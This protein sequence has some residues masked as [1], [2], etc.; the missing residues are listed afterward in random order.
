MIGFI[1]IAKWKPNDQ[2][3]IISGWLL[4]LI[5]LLPCY[6]CFLFRSKTCW[7]INTALKLTIDFFSVYKGMN[8]LLAVMAFI[9]VIFY[10]SLYIFMYIFPPI[11]WQNM[12]NY[13]N[14]GNITYNI[15]FYIVPSIRWNAKSSWYVHAHTYKKKYLYIYKY[16]YAQIN[17]INMK[18]I[19]LSKQQSGATRKNDCFEHI[20]V[21][22]D[23]ICWQTATQY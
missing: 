9:H 18:W 3:S 2:P 17:D 14:Y 6:C 21:W 16:I 8:N 13:S 11:S 10:F 15:N 19:N 12:K 5:L 4:L 23:L 1:F 20:Y 7:I 22:N